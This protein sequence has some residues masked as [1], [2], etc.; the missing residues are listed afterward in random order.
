MIVSGKLSTDGCGTG[1]DFQA[2]DHR[3]TGARYRA[4]ASSGV[5]IVI[6]FPA[7]GLEGLQRGNPLQRPLR[8]LTHQG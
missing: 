1:E 3:R 2:R 4:I 6:P 8:M 5:T 7:D